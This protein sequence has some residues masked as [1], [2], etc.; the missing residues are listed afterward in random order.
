MSD[1]NAPSRRARFDAE[2]WR[3]AL[4]AYV[5]WLGQQSGSAQRMWC[6]HLNARDD[7]MAEAAVAEAVVWDYLAT[8][9]DEV[10]LNEVAG[11]GGADFLCRVGDKQFVVEVTNLSIGKTARDSGLPHTDRHSGGYGLLTQAVR[12]KVQRKFKQANA[13]NKLPVLVVVSTLHWNASISCVRRHAIEALMTS[14]PM[15]TMDIDMR[16]GRVAD[17]YQATDLRHSVFLSE[18]VLYDAQGKPIVRAEFEP[19]S[20]FIVA[21]MG[22][23]PPDV[24]MF[25][26][27]NPGAVRPFDVSLLPQIPFCKF[28]P[29]PPA[30]GVLSLSWSVTEEEEQEKEQAERLRR[31]NRDPQM[32]EQWKM[33]ERELEA[34]KRA[35]NPSGVD[36]LIL[37]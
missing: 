30:D 27:L 9:C 36:R 24:N 5:R 21:G 12:G 34:R 16:T 19:I 13:E 2:L 28:D 8:F 37:P 1:E 11:V 26:G 25:G 35:E 10:W 7:P 3:P 23:R 22:A 33:I 29:W 6:K 15:L 14:T 4:V 32:R 17:E 20:G 18:Q 31:L